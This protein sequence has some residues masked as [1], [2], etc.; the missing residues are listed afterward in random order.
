MKAADYIKENEQKMIED[1]RDIAGIPSILDEGT[2]GKGRPFGSKISEALDCILKKASHMDMHVKN[3]DG[4]A[5]E[6]TLGDGNKMV[7]ILGH[8]DVVA[9]GEGWDTEPFDIQ[10]I[11]GRLYGRGTADDKGPIVSGLYAM[12]YMMDE[13]LLPPDTCIRMIIGTDE[14]ENWECIDHYVAAADRLPDYS[15]VPDGNFPL[16]N[17]EKGLLD[18]DFSY[19]APLADAEIRVAELYGGSAKNVVPS[20][21][22]CKLRCESAETAKGLADA[23]D[24]LEY[25]SAASDGKMTNVV[26]QGKG[27]HAMSPEKGRNAI[28]LLMRALEQA[29]GEYEIEPVF[30]TYNRYIGMA[31]NGEKFGCAFADDVSGELTFNIGTIELKDGRIALGASVR[32]P[33]SIAQETVVGAIRNTCE[34]AGIQM[35]IKSHMASLY[36]KEESDFVQ[37]LLEAYSEVSEDHGS[38]PIAIGGATYARAIPN[39]VAFG[40]LFPSEEELAHEPNEYLS[41]ESLRK[42]TLIYIEA[43]KRLVEI[44]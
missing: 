29:A 30:E 16:I 21:A 41:L 38:K 13:N 31:Y 25:I 8:I 36:V 32:Y 37:V 28:S 2:A 3:Y 33:A 35:E 20:K 12:K 7:G 27:T 17:C 40:P 14:E 34:A 26:A 1:I 23:L 42:M 43:L 4:Y 15:I 19:A 22:F 10:I 6:I 5:G 24:A 39:A 18:I 9:A 44:V 11:D